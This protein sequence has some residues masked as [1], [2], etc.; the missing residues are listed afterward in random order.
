MRVESELGRRVGLDGEPSGRGRQPEAKSH[1]HSL[2]DG[3]SKLL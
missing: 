3:F 2:R 1:G